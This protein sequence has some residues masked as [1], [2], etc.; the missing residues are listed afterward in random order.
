MTRR[1]RAGQVTAMLLAGPAIIAIGGLLF[2]IG[3]PD[4]LVGSVQILGWLGGAVLI[5]WAAVILMRP[6]PP[7]RCAMIAVL[8]IPVFILAV[9]LHNLVSAIFG[10]E[11]PVF[12][13]IALV[14][15]PAML[16]GGIIAGLLPRRAPH[17]EDGG[18]GTPAAPVLR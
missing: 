17:D 13:L 3:A 18:T 7:S 8:A 6:L 16:I 5:V 14:V 9:L 2:A 10:G 15:A 11:E 1:Q 12:F 4:W